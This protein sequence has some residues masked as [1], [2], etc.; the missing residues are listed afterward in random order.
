M[1]RIELTPAAKLFA[2]KNKINVAKLVWEMLREFDADEA[3]TLYFDV[4]AMTAA[5]DICQEENKDGAPIFHIRLNSS[6]E[7]TKNELVFSL[8]HETGHL[9]QM[10]KKDLTHSDCGEYAY[11]REK[12]FKIALTPY[13]FRPWEKSANEMAAQFLSICAQK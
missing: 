4:A 7:R 6:M 3:F 5:A 2:A 11:W 1:Q 13:E 12:S 8:A 9:V 10:L